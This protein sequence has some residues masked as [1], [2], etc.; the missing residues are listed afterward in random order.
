MQSKCAREQDGDIVAQLR[1]L[2]FACL[3]FEAAAPDALLDAWFAASAA[4]RRAWGSA[5]TARHLDVAGATDVAQI[6]ARQGNL[7]CLRWAHEHGCVWDAN[8]SIHAAANGHLDCLQYAREHGCIW[9]E[10]PFNSITT[11]LR[12]PPTSRER[13]GIIRGGARRSPP[14]YR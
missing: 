6:S 5:L 11:N 4:Q 10:I 12:P 8:I 13:G 3:D 2:A 1:A 9:D 7:R 14:L